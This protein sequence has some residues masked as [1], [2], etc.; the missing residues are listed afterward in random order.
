[1]LNDSIY[2]EAA[3]LQTAFPSILRADYAKILEKKDQERGYRGYIIPTMMFT[4]IVVVGSGL[5][6][7]DT[8]D[9]HIFDNYEIL[10]GSQPGEEEAYR[11][12]F[13]SFLMMQ[14]AFLGAFLWSLQHLLRRAQ[15]RDIGPTTI[16]RICLYMLFGMVLAIF[17]N[18]AMSGALSGV[19]PISMEQ[20]L[21]VSGFF[22]G[23]FS[24]EIF[25]KVTEWALRKKKAIRTDEQPPPLTVIEGVSYDT[26]V[27]L[28]ELWVDDAYALAHVNPLEV[29]LKTP[30]GLEQCIDWVAQ[31][32]LLMLV[33]GEAFQVLRRLGIRTI[34]QLEPLLRRTGEGTTAFGRFFASYGFTDAEKDTVRPVLLALDSHG[35]A[36][37]DCDLTFRRLSQLCTLLHPAERPAEAEAVIAVEAPP[38]AAPRRVKEL[39]SVA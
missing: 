33:K 21:P 26:A 20:S 12:A 24:I 8:S 3:A 11:Q 31:A 28:R 27:R 37:L 35:A 6:L 5:M 39:E 32:Q 2:M 18:H 34:L 16:Y 29:Y 22:T 1:M 19:A 10:Y 4:L 36:A 30:F 15:A 38:A 25:E 14:A 17:V 13:N 23:Y 7:F 9:H